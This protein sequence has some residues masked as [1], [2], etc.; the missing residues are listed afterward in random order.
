MAIIEIDDSED[1][2]LRLTLSGGDEVDLFFEGD[3]VTVH[4]N[5][6]K[7]GEISF[8][9]YEQPV[10]PYEDQTIARLTHAFIEG[11]AGRY[12]G[13]GIGTEAIRFFLQ[14]TGYTLELPENDG[15]R[16]ADGSHLVGDGPGFVESLRKKV[17]SNRL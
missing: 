7:V 15:I 12:K 3:S 8:R 4:A 10:S 2:K 6:S 9:C 17:L 16:K 5:G 13:H 11:E 1:E 14:C